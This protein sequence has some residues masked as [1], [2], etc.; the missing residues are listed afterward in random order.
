MKTLKLNG[1]HSHLEALVDDEDWPWLMVYKWH[2]LIDKGGKVYVGTTINGQNF[3]LHRLILASQ[4]TKLDNLV[5]DHIDS[6]PLNNQKANL[7]AV[8]NT[9]NVLSGKTKRRG[10]VLYDPRNKHWKALIRNN[11]T[12]HFVGNFSSEELGWQAMENF[13]AK[14]QIQITCPSL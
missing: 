5:V 9:E 12:R 10:S 3:K 11:G 8:T 14:K 6:N 2:G 1:K 13:I 4:N 7:R